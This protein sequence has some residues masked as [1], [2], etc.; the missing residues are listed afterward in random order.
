MTYLIGDSIEIKIANGE[1]TQVLKIL[2]LRVLALEAKFKNEC[3]HPETTGN[4]YG[5][6]FI[7]TV[8]GEAGLK[9][10]KNYE[11]ASLDDA[12]A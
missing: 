11:H 10:H 6:N 1:V 9:R 8:C 5:I 7:C 3:E 12:T 2:H 4:I